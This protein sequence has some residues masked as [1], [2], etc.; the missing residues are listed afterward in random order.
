MRMSALNVGS[1]LSGGWP[2]AGGWQGSRVLVGI[3]AL[4]LPSTSCF[5]PSLLASCRLLPS[6]V[7]KE[8][9]GKGMGKLLL[10]LVCLRLV[11]HSLGWRSLKAESFSLGWQWSLFQR[12]LFWAP[13][14]IVF[15][16]EERTFPTPLVGPS[17]VPGNLAF[18]SLFLWGSLCPF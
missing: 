1:Q 11:S 13:C 4:F 7:V 8:K 17:T 6:S 14:S 3:F 15:L 10:G 12:S 2:W 18:A 16:S 9:S 5:R